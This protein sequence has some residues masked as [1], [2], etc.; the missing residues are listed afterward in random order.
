MKVKSMKMAKVDV[1]KMSDEEL[2]LLSTLG[3]HEALE[4]VERLG[5]EFITQ[6]IVAGSDNPD[7]TESDA[8]EIL[9]NMS[10]MKTALQFLLDSPKRA[11][12]ELKSRNKEE[13]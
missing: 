8:K 12:R 6:M 2:E 3:N 13:A 7:I 1:A 9:S 5:Q 4:L 10:T 11:K